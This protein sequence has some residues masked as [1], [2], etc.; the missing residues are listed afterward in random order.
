MELPDRWRCLRAARAAAHPVGQ[1]LTILNGQHAMNKKPNILFAFA[2]DWGRYARILE[3][4]GITPVPPGRS[5]CL[6]RLVILYETN[7]TGGEYE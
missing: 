5:G 6:S 1:A 4:Q 2:D 3:K 7:A